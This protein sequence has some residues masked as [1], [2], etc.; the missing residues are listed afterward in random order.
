[1]AVSKSGL[2]ASEIDEILSLA[3]GGSVDIQAQLA[4]IS[5]VFQ[6]L[7][8]NLDGKLP[9][10]GQLP[11]GSPSDDDVIAFGVDPGSG[12]YVYKKCPISGLQALIG[13]GGGGSGGGALAVAQRYL[14]FATTGQTTFHGVDAHGN[15]LS[16]TV[17]AFLLFRNGML[18]IP[19]R[20]YTATDGSNITLSSACSANDVISV[21]T[22]AAAGSPS[23]VITVA[24]GGTGATSV[25]GARA[26]LGAMPDFSSVSVSAP[27]LTDDVMFRGAS[28]AKNSFSGI[29]AAHGVVLYSDL[30]TRLTPKVSDFSLSGGTKNVDIYHAGFSIPGG[31]TGT[32]SH[33]ITYTTPSPGLFLKA[34]F[35][36]VGS[37][38]NGEVSTDQTRGRGGGGGE[39]GI[40]AALVQGDITFTIAQNDVSGSVTSI[41]GNMDFNDSGTFAHTTIQVANGLAGDDATT[42]GGGGA[43]PSGSRNVFTRYMA[44]GSGG[45]AKVGVTGPGIGGGGGGSG[46]AAGADR[47]NKST[48]GHGGAGYGGGGGGGGTTRGQGGA[49]GL[50]RYTHIFTAG[51]NSDEDGGDGALFGGGGGGGNTPGTGAHGGIVVIPLNWQG[52]SP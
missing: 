25:A 51:D 47:N 50:W 9:L 31:A 23:G 36:L 26:A 45:A 5:S 17:G 28:A 34:C 7:A 15:A 4:H 33:T 18:L 48:G 52:A 24:Q 44:G 19:A 38:G 49:V 20:D 22:L 32:G 13:G 12:T 1:M 16:Y 41:T 46:G 6:T 35:I 27:A 11:S 43:T 14:Y 29:Y 37:G 2:F 39:A 42:P 3:P 40:V 8:S 30:H 21:L 10:P